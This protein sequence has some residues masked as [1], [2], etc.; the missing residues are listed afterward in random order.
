MTTL[1][2]SNPELL[3]RSSYISGH[4]LV[5]SDS[6]YPVTNPAT[7]AV[8]CRVTDHGIPETQKAILAA[9]KALPQWRERSA[10][11]RAQI[12]R[13]WY[14]LIL[15]NCEDLA[16]I[17][18]AEQGKVFEESRGEIDYGASY[19]EWFSEEAKRICGDII[20]PPSAD[21]RILVIKQPVGVVAAITP[22]NFPIAMIARKVAPALAAG[23]TVVAK[24]AEDTPLS[25]LALAYLGAEAGIPDGVFNV[26]CGLDSAAIGQ[27]LTS[28]PVVRKVTFTGSTAVGKTLLAQSAA[29]VKKVSMEL[30]GNAPLIIFDDADLDLAIRGAMISKFR[31]AGQTCVCSNRLF[32]Q[33]GIYDDF[34]KRLVHEV[35]NLVVGEGMAEGVDIGP[36]I[37]QK[38]VAGVHDKVIDAVAHGARVLIGGDVDELG[39]S[40]YQPTVLAGVVPSMRLFNEEIFGP[41]A[42]VF[43]FRDESEVLAL[44][45]ASESGLAAYCYTSDMSRCFRMA[46]RLEYGMVGINDGA[47]SNEMAPF[48]GIKES[49]LGR[50]GSRYG[51]DDYLEIKYVSFGGV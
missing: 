51:I 32:V 48:G 9:E 42:P 17:L 40:F 50:E 33:E 24:P 22:W 15:E 19:I 14:D 47:L 28:N 23:C 11:E 12:L 3:R 10:K 30:G 27:E 29:T 1:K 26:I 35:E 39:P 41:V 4:W 5:D 37:H 34:L 8:I 44:A 2:V 36:L 7:G 25:C 21:K 43:K 46:E 6:T 20:A 16:R 49:G 13:R 45:N 18:T 38:A 31:N